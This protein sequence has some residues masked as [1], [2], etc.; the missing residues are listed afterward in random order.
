MFATGH[1]ECRNENCM[2][3]SN[4]RCSSCRR[5]DA[6]YIIA[7]DYWRVKRS[8]KP[9]LGHIDKCNIRRNVNMILKPIA[10][11]IL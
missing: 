7:I 4:C 3:I 9:Y 5:R 11:A 8:L 10:R 6:K 2:T 1:I